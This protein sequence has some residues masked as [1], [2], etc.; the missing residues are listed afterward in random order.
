[1]VRLSQEDRDLFQKRADAGTALRSDLLDRISQLWKA[2]SEC[3][4]AQAAQTQAIA[5]L[6]LALGIDLP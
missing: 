6:R 1:V 2:Q 5:A 4:Q 3:A